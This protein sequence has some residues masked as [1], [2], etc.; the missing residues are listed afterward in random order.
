V[1]PPD[2]V[3]VVPE[4]EPVPNVAP[5]I[6]SSRPRAGR[7]DVAEG[8]AVDFEVR[9]TD[10]AADALRYTWLIDGR[11][12]ARTPR[13][14]FVAPSAAGGV[15]RTVEARVSDAPGLAAAPVSWTVAVG[16]RMSEA[17]VRGWLERVAA[18]WQRGDVATLRLYGIASGDPDGARRGDTVTIVNE[19]IRTDGPYATVAF[20][21]AVRR[22]RPDRLTGRES[23]GS[24]SSRAGS[25]RAAER[26]SG[27]TRER[28]SAA[29]RSASTRR[30]PATSRSVSH[31]G[32]GGRSSSARQRAPPPRTRA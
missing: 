5:R 1:E 28:R 12:V 3:V 17:D 30:T 6:V 31:Q 29:A 7:L 25:S 14:R 4:P 11:V 32:G 13:W 9:A 19:T 22:A 10:D 15:V 27:T 2:A 24:R 18:A 26:G 8:A 20:D 23:F 16:P 21:R